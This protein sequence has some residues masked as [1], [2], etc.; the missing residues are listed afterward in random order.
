MTYIENNLLPNE[1]IIYEGKIHGFYIF[2]LVMWLIIG[3]IFFL[4]WLQVPPMR[5]LWFWMIIGFGYNILFFKLTEIAVTNK[6]VIFKTW[7]IARNVFELQLQKV[8]SARL[9][10]SIIERII[11]A[12]TLVVSWTWGHNKPMHYIT[13]PMEMRTVIYEEIEKQKML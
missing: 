5:L 9:D 12:G 11:W 13:K 4:I 7:V 2:L 1:E 8:E 6:R 10:Q 3:M